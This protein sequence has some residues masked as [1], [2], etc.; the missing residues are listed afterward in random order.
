MH[1][2]V[3][4]LTLGFQVLLTAALFVWGRWVGRRQ[5]WN[6]V[7]WLPVVAGVLWAL[8]FGGTLYGLSRSFRAV[9]DARPEEKARLLAEGIDTAMWATAVLGI[10][11]GAIYLVAIAIFLVG[12]FRVAP[13]R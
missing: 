4:V 12:T 6:R 7:A 9:A 8:G 3:F 10:P 5:G 2:A 1:V 11:A 13:V